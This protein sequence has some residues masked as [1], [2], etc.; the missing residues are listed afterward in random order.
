[1]KELL[2][3]LL[4][5]IKPNELVYISTSTGSRTVICREDSCFPVATS[6]HFISGL[7]NLSANYLSEYMDPISQ[8]SVI[9][10]KTKHTIELDGRKY[11]IDNEILNMKY[12]D[13]FM[14]IT[15]ENESHMITRYIFYN[16][17]T[18]IYIVKEG[19]EI[20]KQYNEMN[21]SLLKNN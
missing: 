20:L 3:N 16:T 11:L 15:E 7:E 21:Y 13:N 9:D 2:F 1:M 14:E 18:E 19:N 12:H 17:I 6:M 4:E 8:K 10:Y 5:E